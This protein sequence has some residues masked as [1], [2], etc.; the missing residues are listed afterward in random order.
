MSAVCRVFASIA[1][2]ACF[3]LLCHAQAATPATPPAAAVAAKADY[4]VQQVRPNLSVLMSSGGNIAVW[5]GP[6]GTVLVDDGIAGLAPQLQE[7]LARVARTPVRFVVNTHWHPDH[8]GGNEALAKAGATVVAH[9]SVRE[10]MSR[11]QVV[12]EYDTKVPASP[13]AA[14]P[15]VTFAD[16]LAIQLDGERIGIVHVADAHTDS[17]VIVRWQ[18]ANAVHVGDLFYNGGYPF[19]DVASGGSLA[20]V[21]AALEAVLARSDAQTAVIPGHGPVAT[22]AE[23]AAYRDMLVAVGRKVRE[24]VEAGSSLDE[25]LALHLTGDFDERYAKGAVSPER[26]VRTVYRDLSKPRSGR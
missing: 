12:E 25:V 5:S 15:V 9:E 26:F 13:A 16:S 8:T 22:R 23:L 18:E 4:R 21:V 17:D 20:G 24:Q 1:C 3:P 2:L 19:I 7:A 14:L 10:R 6:S 11:P